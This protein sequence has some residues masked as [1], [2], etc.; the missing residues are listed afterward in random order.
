MIIF[1]DWWNRRICNFFLG[2]IELLFIVAL[3][4]VKN[5]SL[6][7]RLALVDSL[8][9]LLALENAL[10]FLFKHLVKTLGFIVDLPSKSL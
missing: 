6:T 10:F 2:D 8:A 3:T 7:L 4:V 5:A 9:E 1:K